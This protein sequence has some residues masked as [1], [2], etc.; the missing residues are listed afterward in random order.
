[1]KV[2]ISRITE[3]ERA[4]ENKKSFERIS[5]NICSTIKVCEN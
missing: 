4:D 5:R 3:P 2:I 1:M